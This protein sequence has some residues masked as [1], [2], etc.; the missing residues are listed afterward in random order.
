MNILVVCDSNLYMDFSLSFVHAQAAA[1][2][3]LGHRVRVIVPY[4]IGKRDW[5]GNRFSG[6][7]RCWDRDGVEIYLMRHISISNCG[8]KGFNLNSALR[9][10]PGKLDKLL[11]GFAPDI[12]HAHALGFNSEIGAFFKARLG[13]PLVVTSHGSDTSV[14][15]EQGRKAELRRYCDKADAVVAVSSALAKKVRSS[16]TKTPVS[17]ILNGFRMQNLPVGNAERTFS[18]IQVGHL[19]RQKRPHV[20]IQAFARL[21]AAHPD[22]A[23]TLIGQGPERDSL[24]ALCQEVG[25][26][27]A[28]RFLGEIPNPSVLTEMGKAQFFVMPSVNE[29]FGI[30]YL[31]AMASG[32]IT[33][34]TDGEGI[35]DVIVSGKNGFLVPSDDPDAIVQIIEWC[36]KHP[37]E[38]SAIAEQGRQDA[39]DL[40]WEN[41]ASQY[42]EHFERIL[43]NGT[44]IGANF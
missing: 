11:K 36:L 23:M 5:D 22:A 34:G 37:D 2:A 40:T 12:I 41:N 32:C 9:V 3:A 33:I 17:V 26:S 27:G 7:I 25:V 20:T 8:K 15:I 13:L 18:L 29:G 4:A 19:L 1:Y 28:V 43:K 44:E 6:P 31:E 21:R 16:G 10:L 39:L 14:P 35:A 24:E 38:A 42:V 30:V